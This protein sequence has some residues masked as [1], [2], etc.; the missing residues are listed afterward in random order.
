VQASL[1]LA[2]NNLGEPLPVGADLKKKLLERFAITSAQS[3]DLSQLCTVIE[4]SQAS[5]LRLFFKQIFTVRDFDPRYLQLDQLALR[6]VFTTNIDDLM[7][8]IFASA[9]LRYLNDITMNGPARA[10][11]SAV[12]YA[13]LHGTVQNDQSKLTF[14]TTDIASAFAADPDLWHLLTNQMQQLPTLFWGYS[15]ADAGILQALNPGTTRGRELKDRWVILRAHDPASEE[16]FRAL[17]FNRNN[18]GHVQFP[19]LS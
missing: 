7:Y 5:E 18:R 9:H 10:D 15:L 14:S 11:K 2:N 6:Y 17:R 13:P 19:G 1:S 4:A 16:Y 12:N 3:L 8:K